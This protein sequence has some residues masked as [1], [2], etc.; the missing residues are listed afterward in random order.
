MEQLRDFAVM[1]GDE[2]AELDGKLHISI[3]NRRRE[4][5]AT[6]SS[7]K[8]GLRPARDDKVFRYFGA[9]KM[10]I[11]FGERGYGCRIGKEN[12]NILW[13]SGQF[14]TFIFLA[15]VHLEVCEEVAAVGRFGRLQQRISKEILVEVR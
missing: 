7:Y 10:V 3:R 14:S 2:E 11:V 12:A 5:P 15:S 6:T 4:R 1:K 13:S 8:E 9:C